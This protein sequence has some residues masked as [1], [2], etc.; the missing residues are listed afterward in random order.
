MHDLSSAILSHEGSDEIE[1]STESSIFDEFFQNK[2]GQ[3]TILSFSLRSVISSHETIV[4][5]GLIITTL[6]PLFP[7]PGRPTSTNPQQ[8]AMSLREQQ[9][10][11][12]GDAAAAATQRIHVRTRELGFATVLRR[13]NIFYDDTVE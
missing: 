4:D 8:H 10:G 2:A 13:Q 3:I 6:H 5:C 9:G 11:W 1:P 7:H 12:H